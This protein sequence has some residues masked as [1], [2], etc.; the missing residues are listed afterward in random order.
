VATAAAINLFRAI[1]WLND[2]P[3]AATRTSRLA[4]LAA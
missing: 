4:A 3:L 1:N 2:V